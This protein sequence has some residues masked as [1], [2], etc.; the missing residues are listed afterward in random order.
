MFGGLTYIY[1]YLEQTAKNCLPCQQVKNIPTVAPL[2]PW[3]WPSKPWQHIHIDFAEPMK[4][5]MY[6]VTVDAHSKWPDVK[7]LSGTS[8]ATTI[9]AL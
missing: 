3:V 5:R 8:A 7:E 1:Q 6:L 9:Q 4:G 2:H